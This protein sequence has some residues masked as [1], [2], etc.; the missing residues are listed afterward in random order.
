MQTQSA[1][2][3]PRDGILRGPTLM[4]TSE[5][6]YAQSQVL[7]PYHVPVGISQQ[8]KQ[9]VISLPP[10][11]IRNNVPNGDRHPQIAP[12]ANA[13]PPAIHHWTSDPV[14]MSATCIPIG[15]NAHS[16]TVGVGM[17]VR[18]QQPLQQTPNHWLRV[19]A[20]QRTGIGSVDVGSPV[21][22]GRRM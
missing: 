9:P 2:T 14:Q 5:Q 20:P 11:L 3:S 7:R 1:R 19:S 13:G 12:F 16:G 10:P 6:V 21:L 15:A 22:R 4:T 17:G 8:E 18:Y